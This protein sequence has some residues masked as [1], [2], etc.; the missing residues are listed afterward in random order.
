MDILSISLYARNVSH[1]TYLYCQTSS[2]YLWVAR[3][4]IISKLQAKEPP[5]LSS[6]SGTRGGKF[7]SVSNVSAQN[8]DSSKN[9]HIFN[10]RVMVVRDIKL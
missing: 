2:V 5:K 7:I 4:V 10:F 1:L 8:H 6:L 9:R 3:D